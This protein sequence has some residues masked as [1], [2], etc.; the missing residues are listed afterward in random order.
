MSVCPKCLFIQGVSSNSIFLINYLFILQIMGTSI[1]LKIFK[2]LFTPF[3]KK[4][5]FLFLK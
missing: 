4:L 1:S 5:L 3:I 2:K